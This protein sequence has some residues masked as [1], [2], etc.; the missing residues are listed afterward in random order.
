MTIACARLCLDWWREDQILEVP[1]SS[2]RRATHVWHGPHHGLNY[3]CTY[4]ATAT[5][6]A[7]VTSPFSNTISASVKYSKKHRL[8]FK[9]HPRPWDIE[10]M[11]PLMQ[12]HFQC[13]ADLGGNRDNDHSQTSYLGYLT[14]NLICWCSTDQGS[15]HNDIKHSIV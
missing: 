9:S 13:D 12:L 6:Q 8:M 11:T 2:R 3:V 15:C 7:I 10:M 5:T 1:V 14:G 4:P